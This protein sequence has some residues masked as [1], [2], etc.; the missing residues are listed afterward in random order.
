MIL[1]RTMVKKA[2]RKVRLTALIN[3]DPLELLIIDAVTTR[4][5]RGSEALYADLSCED[6]EYV[7]IAA[8]PE[9]I[10]AVLVKKAADLFCLGSSVN[11]PRSLFC[12][13]GDMYVSSFSAS[14]AK[15]LI[16]DVSVL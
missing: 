9:G 10:R 8:P 4:Y 3:P 16:F 15:Y 14:A 12:A 1:E 6:E 7:D 2:R 11:S 5:F 13:Y